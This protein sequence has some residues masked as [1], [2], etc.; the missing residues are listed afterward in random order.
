MQRGVAVRRWLD[1]QWYGFLWSE[2]SGS[3]Q[4]AVAF[5]ATAALAAAGFFAVQAI[6]AGK[7]RQ[8]ENAASYVP[9]TVTVQK[10]VRVMEHGRV[11][12]KRVPVVRRIYA[13]PV[14]VLEMTTRTTPQ[15]TVV[16]TNAVVRYKPV[17]RRVVVTVKGRQVTVSRPVTDTRVLTQTQV[18]TQT[19]QL[20]VVNDR[21]SVVTQNNTVRETNIVRET[22]TV[23]ST[24]TNN[25]TVVDTQTVTQPVTVTTPGETVI[26]T[27]PVTVTH[28]VT[29]TV[30]TRDGGG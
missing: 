15:G 19:Q 3:V 8:A 21:T 25:R 7:P 24:V 18:F 14:T 22:S 28:E 12:V 9:V 30:T 11:V 5:A 6:G 10:R 29:V 20:T 27:E 2:A 13:K 4:L 17:Y 23:L 26:V 1:P 16:L